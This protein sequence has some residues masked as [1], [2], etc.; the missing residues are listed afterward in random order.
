MDN[1]NDLEN[2]SKFILNL[3]PKLEAKNDVDYRAL[4]DAGKAMFQ[5]FKALTESGFTEHQA[6]ILVSEFLKSSVSR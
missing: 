1:D 6:L 4:V 5:V 2:D 3:L